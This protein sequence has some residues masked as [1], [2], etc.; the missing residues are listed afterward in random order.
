MNFLHLIYESFRFAMQALKANVFR[1]ILSLLGVTVGIFS[2]IGVYTMVDSLQK[3]IEGSLS[4]L[5]ANTIHIDKWPW[6]FSGN[7]FPWWKYFL[8]PQPRYEEYRYLRDNLKEAQAV[9][10][11]TARSNI[12]VKNGSNSVQAGIMGVAQE[13][14]IISDVPI[15]DGRWYLPQE[16]DAGRNIAILGFEIAD[17]LFPNESPIGKTIKI[18]GLNFTVIGVQVKQGES[19]AT[20]GN[21]PVDQRVFLPFLSFKKIFSSGIATGV[22]SVKGYETDKDLVQLESEITGLMRTKRALKPSQD[23]DFELNR[24][25]AIMASI[26]SIFDGLRVGGFWIGIFSLL[27]GGFGIANIMFVSVKERTN[28]IGIQKSLGAKN[29]FILFQFLFEAVFL[30]ILGGF[31]GILV[32]YLASFIQLGSL[33]IVLSTNN[34]ILGVAI[35]SF[36]G[37]ISGIVPAWQ[38]SRLNPVDAIRSK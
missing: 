11:F 24:S 16:S 33:D 2:I 20:V 29:Y 23:N 27:I 15:S 3:N 34:I 4:T 18:K 14:N 35:A 26:G 17:N 37:V 9:S 8:R 25:E 1:T 31:F 36:I 38:A 21:T 7:D 5:G 22:I 12:T 6:A 13:Y 10:I 19:I 32:V 28:I 30:C